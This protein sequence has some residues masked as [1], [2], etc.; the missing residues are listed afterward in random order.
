LEA[1]IASHVIN[2]VFVYV[3]ASL[4]T[5]VAAMRAVTESAWVDA[6]LDV[7]GFAAFTVAALLVTRWMR[8]RTR[9]DLATA[10]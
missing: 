8:L 7:G 1:A 2:N 10:Q 4:T 6:A 5:S 3:I 9:V